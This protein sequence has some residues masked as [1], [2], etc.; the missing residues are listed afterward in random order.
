MMCAMQVEDRSPVRFARVDGAALAYQ[1]WGTGPA[2]VVVVPPLAQNIELTW[3]RP[4][5]RAFFARL[6]HF[7]RVLHFDKRGTGASDR[8]GRMPTVDQRV[9]DVVAVMDAAGCDRAHVLGL[10][11][12]GS[13]A[14]A[15]A[16]TYPERVETL[17]LFASGARMVGDETDEQRATRRGAVHLFHERWGTDESVTLGVFA[18]S[19]ADDPGYCAWE[20]RY[21]RQ[22]ATPAALRELLDMIEVIDVRPLLGSVTAPALVLHRR[23]DRVVP[24]ALARETAALLPGARL[25]E[26]EG[27]DHFVHV[28]DVDSWVDHFERFVAG[29]VSLRRDRPRDREVRIQTMGGFH[30]HVDGQPVPARAWGSRQAR[31]VCKRLA[32]AVDRAIPR[33]ELTEL[34]WPEEPDP[35]KRSAR[36]SV[37]LSNIRRVLGGGLVA[38]RDAVQLDLDAVDLDLVGLS[39]AITRG[40]DRAVVARHVG[41]VLPEEAYEDWAITA[42]HRFCAAVVSARRRLANDAAAHGRW[43]EVV[44]HAHAT[45]ELDE[46]DERAHELLVQALV[47]DGRRGE[48]RL[49]VARYEA[50][51]SDLGVQPRDLLHAEHSA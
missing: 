42:R 31:L 32:V 20:P 19:V 4:E 26:V 2:R 30:V 33:D 50:C 49:A 13:V 43:D 51:M 39:E 44:D 10:S 11:E 34:L 23:H 28:G 14:I 29:A 36:L 6:G 35:T 37:V 41:P 17:T 40:D 15:L 22:S 18:P 7:A 16:A 9:E 38:D 25:V 45:L 47:A 5:Y 48:A 3:E 46:F 12:G 8:T 24:V 21:E 27:R 1:T